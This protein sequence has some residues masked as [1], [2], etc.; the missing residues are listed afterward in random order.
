MNYTMPLPYP[1][2]ANIPINIRYD[3][4]RPFV[5]VARR[6]PAAM[7]PCRSSTLAEQHF[8]VIHRP[9]YAMSQLQQDATFTASYRQAIDEGWD[10]I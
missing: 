3:D 4:D 9:A 6:L 10:V 5:R 7:P 8:N 1:A 2:H